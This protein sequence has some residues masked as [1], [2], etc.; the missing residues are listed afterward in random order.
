V[1]IVLRIIGVRHKAFLYW[2]KV[3]LSEVVVL[4]IID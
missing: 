2:A 3:D 1:D 4:H